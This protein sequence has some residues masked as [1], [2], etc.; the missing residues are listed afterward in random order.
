MAIID[1][2]NILWAG[3]VVD[4]KTDYSVR[5]MSDVWSD[6]TY[7]VVYSPETEGEKH[8]KYGEPQNGVWHLV[9]VGST[10]FPS[11]YKKT[12]VDAPQEII[13]LYKQHVGKI[14]LEAEQRQAAYDAEQ[15]ALRIKEAL[16]RV[17]K[18]RIVE[19]Y[20]GRKVKIGTKGEIFWIG[21]DSFGKE[22][23]GIKTSNRKENGK[24][25]DV[26]WV[27]SNNCRVINES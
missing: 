26:I 22:K 12:A 17:E 19:V 25:L 5:I 6:E 14:K 16:E 2:V 23:L 8:H 3:R 1:G 7:A 21:V 13:E 4:I 15:K 10:E 11:A 9:H 20:K 18:G 27:A 24:W